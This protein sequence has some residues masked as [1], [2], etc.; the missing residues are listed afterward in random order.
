MPNILSHKTVKRYL[1]NVMI[2]NKKVLKY[3]YCDTK[4]I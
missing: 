4:I 2:L 1:Y 3:M